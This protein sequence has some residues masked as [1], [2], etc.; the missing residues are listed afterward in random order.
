MADVWPCCGCCCYILFNMKKLAAVQRTVGVWPWCWCV[1]IC[2]TWKKL[3]PVQRMAGVWPCW[4]CVAAFCSTKEISSSAVDGW[5]RWLCGRAVDVLLH[6]VQHE[7]VSRSTEN[8]WCVAM[9]GVLLYV[10]HEEVSTSAKDGWCVAMLWVLFNMKKLAAAQ[11]MAGVWEG[12]RG[13]GGGGEVAT[14]CSTWS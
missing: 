8:R 7:E 5:C 10:Q 12:G 3:A 14:C 6:I 13:G 4:V 11:W 1:A 2:S 9:L